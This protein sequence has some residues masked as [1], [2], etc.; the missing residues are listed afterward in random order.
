MNRAAPH[1][2]T[3]KQEHS[4]GLYRKKDGAR[5]IL[6]KEKTELF[7]GQDIFWGGRRRKKGK[8]LIM[9]IYSFRGGNG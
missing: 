1:P 3:T 5:E 9:Q 4:N 2:T 7:G 8:V 6:T